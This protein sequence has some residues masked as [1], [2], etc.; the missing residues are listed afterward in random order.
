MQ[1]ILEMKR[2]VLLYAIHGWHEM[3]HGVD[4]RKSKDYEK[5]IRKIIE[6]GG[7]PQLRD[8]YGR[9]ALHLIIQF[10]FTD[11]LDVVIKHTPKMCTSISAVKGD[12][13]VSKLVNNYNDWNVFHYISYSR[14]RFKVLSQLLLKFSYSEAVLKD[15]FQY[16]SS[17]WGKELF[18][19]FSLDQAYT[20]PD[21]N[22]V[23]RDYIFPF[24]ENHSKFLLER[25]LDA[26]NANLRDFDAEALAHTVNYS[27]FT[28]YH[29][30]VDFGDSQLFSSLSDSVPIS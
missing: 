1:I 25:V 30:I 4:K 5:I 17:A 10:G 21:K 28:P 27:G 24:I 15:F 18:Q 3:L 29:Q 12:Q 16:F 11:L 19:E 13:I 22:T 14:F 23:S 26:C 8:E 9:N 20:G 2:T 7:K 6:K